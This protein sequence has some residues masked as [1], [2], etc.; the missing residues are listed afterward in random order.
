MSRS[1][2]CFVV[3]EK[4]VIVKETCG[5]FKELLMPG[6]HFICPLV[7]AK[8]PYSYDYFT[9]DDDKM[10]R[11]KKSEKIISL[12]QQS[13]EFPRFEVITRDNIQCYIDL[14][15]NY[16]VINAHDLV[17]NVKNMPY[18]LSL[19]VNAIV[20]SQCGEM[21]LDN[22]I[23]DPQQISRL[24]GE[25]QEYV[26]DWGINIELFKV[27]KVEAK[28]R[29]KEKLQLTKNAMY[30]CESSVRTKKTEQQSIIMKAAASRDQMIKQ[31]EGKSQSII[32]TQEG[33][34]QA[35]KN[36]GQAHANAIDSLVPGM[37][38][39]AAAFTLADKTCDLINIINKQTKSQIM[40]THG[41]DKA[42]VMKCIIGG[43]Q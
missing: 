40:Y 19:L 17:Y 36:R 3:H 41:V 38:N 39:R 9:F 29:L 11:I 43:Y 1:I 14:T 2:C 30:N 4:T 31:A 8:R 16:K 28:E 5:Q 21:D 27:Q 25:L 32:L 37:G 24:I 26:K 20:R 22:I 23:E 6:S 12:Q 18:M 42:E 13:V 7:S 35:I 33:E 34:A 10:K 15:I